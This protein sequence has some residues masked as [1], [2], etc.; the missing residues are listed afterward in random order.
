[1][2]GDYVSEN[3]VWEM[4]EAG[5]SIEEISEVLGITV[6]EVENILWG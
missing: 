1:M 6:N 3:Y 2:E 5:F 4:Y